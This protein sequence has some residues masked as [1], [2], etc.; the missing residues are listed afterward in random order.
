MSI[1]LNN[2]NRILK[3]RKRLM[4]TLIFPVILIALTMMKSLGG[5]L[6]VGVIDK[7]NSRLTQNLI[8]SISLQGEVKLIKEEEVQTYILDSKAD[9]IIKINKGF[10][11][12]IINGKDPFIQGYSSLEGTASSPIKMYIDGL[13]NATKNIA[14][15]SGGDEQRFYEGFDLYNNGSYKAEYVAINEKNDNIDNTFK[16][17]GLMVMSILMFCTTTSSMILKDKQGKIYHRIFSTPIS[18]KNYTLQSILSFLVVAALQ[19]GLLLGIMVYFFKA[20]LG[21]STINM[22]I[23]LL[24]FSFSCVALGVLINSLSKDLN[25]ANA[26]TSLI[27]MPLCMLGG[28][29]WSTEIMPEF[30]RNI[31]NFLPTTWGLKAAREVLYTGTLSSVKIELLIVVMFAVVFF[32]LGSWK[33][34]DVAV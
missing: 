23:V 32:M 31:A 10:A 29:F 1:M 11:K 3:D 6:V 5:Q 25:Q 26:I 9:Y 30:L 8:K 28:C 33:K 4:F 22:Y 19:I 13:I 15:A 20:K 16:A 12:D 7:D 21:P 24:V 18:I 34:S 2:I 27:M 17:L 14:K